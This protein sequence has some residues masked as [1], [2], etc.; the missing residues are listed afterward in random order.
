MCV[1]VCARVCTYLFDHV[2][3]FPLL[4]LQH[5]VKV[6]D[7]LLECGHLFLQ[8]STPEITRRCWKTVG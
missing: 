6:M 3:N 1:G 7:L 8:L 4:T 2:P 5:V